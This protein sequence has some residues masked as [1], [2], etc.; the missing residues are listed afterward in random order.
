MCV[1]LQNCLKV[2]NATSQAKTR[3]HR[4]NAAF[5][6]TEGGQSAPS[7][8][9]P[10]CSSYMPRTSRGTSAPKRTHKNTHTRHDSTYLYSSLRLSTIGRP[11]RNASTSMAEPTA[12][13]RHRPL[14][15]NTRGLSLDGRPKRRRQRPFDKY[16]TPE[17]SLVT[18]RSLIRCRPC[19]ITP[20]ILEEK[21]RRDR[22][23]K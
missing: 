8:S 22:S 11:D 5:L 3:I 1:P 17:S 12:R 18:P 21:I 23:N 9:T 14:G 4:P 2:H 6:L 10:D 15:K 13:C 20:I 19:H 7:T 16:N